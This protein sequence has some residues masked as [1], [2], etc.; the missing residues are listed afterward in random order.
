MLWRRENQA[1]D[2]LS[3]VLLNQKKKKSTQFGQISI[4]IINDIYKCE[5]LKKRKVMR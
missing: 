5:F 2:V 3:K 1:N 4:K